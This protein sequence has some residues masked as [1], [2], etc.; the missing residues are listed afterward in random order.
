A[1]VAHGL[2]RLDVGVLVV[3]PPRSPLP[4]LL[5]EDPGVRVLTGTAVKDSELREVATSFGDGRYVVIVDDVDQ[6]AV[7]ATEQGFSST[8]TLLEE[9]AQPTARGGRALVLTADARPVL[10]GFPG[11]S[12]RLINTALT[13]GHRLLLTPEDRA[14]ALAHNVP[15]DPDQYFTDPPGRGYLVT[16]RTPT[17]LQVAVPVR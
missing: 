2:R 15:L 12:A 6:L 9:V 5:P 7:L 10:T 4:L 3:A 8:P 14:T 11:P 1:V 17:L 13:T 16:G